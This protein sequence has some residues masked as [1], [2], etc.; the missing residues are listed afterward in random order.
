[1]VAAFASRLKDEVG[2]DSIRRDLA[3]TVH[4]ALEPAHV[5]VWISQHD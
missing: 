5:S 4:T 3:G 1:M 2:L